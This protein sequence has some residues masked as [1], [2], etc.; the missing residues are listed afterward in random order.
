MIDPMIKGYGS[1]A[2]RMISA[3][4]VIQYFEHSHASGKLQMVSYVPV[5]Q[6]ALASVVDL[7]PMSNA[8]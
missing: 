2:N 5:H 4:H 6:A 8:C 3:K 1:S 7:L